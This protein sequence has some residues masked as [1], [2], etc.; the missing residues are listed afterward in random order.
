VVVVD[1]TVVD[2]GVVVVVVPGVVVDVPVG[3]VEV[4]VEE[5][6]V[7]VEVLLPTEVV[8][9]VVVELVVELE[10]DLGVLWACWGAE[11]CFAGA[12]VVAPWNWKGFVGWPGFAAP[13][14]RTVTNAA[15]APP[16]ATSEPTPI[17]F[18]T[19]SSRSRRASLRARRSSSG[20]SWARWFI[21]D[22]AGDER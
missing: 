2:V 9:E 19:A 8:V 12:A 1:A 16:T 6:G 13:S 11:S 21:T 17:G 18:N 22:M 15:V 5:L 7:V 20:V 4:V 10:G 3:L 14:A